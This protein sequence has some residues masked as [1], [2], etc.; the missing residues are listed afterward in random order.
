VLLFCANYL[1]IKTFQKWSDTFCRRL[2][3]DQCSN[4]NFHIRLSADSNA[5]ACNKKKSPFIQSQCHLLQVLSR[6]T[7]SGC[8]LQILTFN[9]S[10]AYQSP[11]GYKLRAIIIPCY[12]HDQNSRIRSCRCQQIL[13]RRL[14]K[15]RYENSKQKY[16]NY[17]R[18]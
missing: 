16:R 8:F 17:C 14:R 6:R 9:P 7:R 5:V 12:K 4:Y 11:V 2:R 10:A 18:D 13:W 1:F 3:K 15:H